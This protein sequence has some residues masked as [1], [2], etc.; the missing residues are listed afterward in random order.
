MAKGYWRAVGAK[1]SHIVDEPF[2]SIPID[3]ANCCC[4][5]RL[6]FGASAERRKLA[7][8]GFDSGMSVSSPMIK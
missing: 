8:K 4:L 3:N 5:D 2:C 6:I 7:K 1:L